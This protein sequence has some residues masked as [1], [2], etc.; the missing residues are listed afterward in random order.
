[1]NR[2]MAWGAVAVLAVLLLALQGMGLLLADHAPPVEK[3]RT[4]SVEPG[5]VESAAK[6]EGIEPCFSVGFLTG[7]YSA[8]NRVQRFHA[9]GR[10]ARE[11][12]HEAGAE[13]RA[14]AKTDVAPDVAQQPGHADTYFDPA[15]VSLTPLRIQASVTVKR[16]G[17]TPVLIK[18]E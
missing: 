7:A 12:P 3:F 10:I 16:G 6:G 11:L 18:V 8:A 2:K 14:D 4:V 15:V 9:G 17:P 13:S 5:L 1:M